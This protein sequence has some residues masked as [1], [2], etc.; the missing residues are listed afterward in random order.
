MRFE[1]FEGATP[2][3]GAMVETFTV[4]NIDNEASSAMVSDYGA[5]VLKWAPKGQQAV[6]WC[7]KAIYL[8]EG[9]AIRG[10][11]PIIFPWFNSGFENGHVAAKKP[12]HGFARVSFWKFDAA[13]STQSKLRYEMDSSQ[14]DESILSQFVSGP[15][16]RF[17]AV[18][19]ISSAE[20]LTMSL[21]VTN[22]GTEPLAYEAALHTYLHVAD[23]ERAQVLGLEHAS[24]LDTT[25]DGDPLCES[26]GDPV[27]FNGLVDRIYYSEDTLEVKDDVLGRTLVIAKEGSEQTVVWN[28][29]EKNGN[30]I[31]D[32]QEG[33]WRDFVCVEAVANRDR[34]VSIAAGESHTLSQTISVK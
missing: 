29:G 26:D 33:E 13:G 11:V 4:R 3:S 1:V 32:L 2:Y 23:A 27:S 28:P 24:Y 30:A 7:P 8:N 34:S 16:P 17:H 21:T 15:N 31:G 18:Y 10:G 20:S 9:K 5:H 12:K 14:I 25:L 22:D 6:V 19:E